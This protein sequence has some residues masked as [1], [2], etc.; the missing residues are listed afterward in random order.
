ME[1][2][3]RPYVIGLT[4]AIGTGKSAVLRMLADLGALPLDAD[5]LAHEAMQPGGLA[6]RPVVEAFGDGILNSD[7]TVNRK[8]LGRIVFADAEALQRLERIV[9]PA[10]FQLA[11]ER[12]AQATQPVAVIEAIKLLE[13]GMTLRLCDAVW[14]VTARLDVALARLQAQRGMGE[15]E[16]RRRLAHQMTDAERLARADVVIDNSGTL[17]ETQAQVLAAWQALL[18]TLQDKEQEETA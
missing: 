16:A 6:Y 2:R 4:G 13:S 1:P 9:H 12:I 7:G 5:R 15:G 17:A 14:V 8:A 18:A 11:E 3:G 10:V